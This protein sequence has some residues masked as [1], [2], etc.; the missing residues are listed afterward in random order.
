M[1]LDFIINHYGEE[2]E[3][4]EGAVSPPLMQTNNFCFNTVADMREALT[5]EMH[6]PFYTRGVNPTVRTLRRKLA[7]LEGS[8]ECLVFASGSAAIGA[9]V[10]SSV[11]AGDHIVCVDK[12][13][14]WTN[15]LLARL[16]SRFGVSHTFVDGRDPENFRKAIQPQTRLFILES[17]NSITFELQD[18]AAIARIAKAHDI[19]T[20]IDNS[21]ATPLNQQPLKMGIDMV[22]HSASKYL[23]GHS[24]IVAGVL[25]CSAEKYR[26][27]FE[28][29][30]MTLG[31]VISPHDAWLMLRGLRTLPIR[32]QRVAETTPK[33]VAFLEQHPQV[34]KVNYPYS[35][36]FPQYELAQKQMKAPAGQF[37]MQLKAETLEDIDRFCN[38]LKYFLLACSWGGYESL[39]FPTSAL[40]S[41]QNY[42]GSPLPW[43]L[44][45]F[46]VGLEEADVLIED[47]RQAMEGE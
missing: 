26:Q 5:Q 30:Y 20:L 43:N 1:D 23:N 15:K 16:L 33:V 11:Q 12:P 2:R 38:R 36:S 19:Q 25:C 45:R 39:I 10:M 7:A 24:D 21:Y 46:Y 40:L 47:L 37:S 31:G 22:A 42:S 14:S 34:E 35:P 4:Y 44:I 9:A 13:Y 6:M 29:E 3:Q 8:E 18:I 27:I 28:G 32:M 41:S 17:P